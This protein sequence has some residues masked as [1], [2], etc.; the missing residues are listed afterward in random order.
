MFVNIRCQKPISFFFFCKKE[1]VSGGRTYFRFSFRTQKRTR[2]GNHNCYTSTK[3]IDIIECIIWHVGYW[4]MERTT[5][6]VFWC[7]I[8]VVSFRCFD[9]QL[10]F[11]L[12]YFCWQHF[13]PNDD[14]SEHLP[15][16][17][18]MDRSIMN[19]LLLPK[20]DLHRSERDPMIGV[21]KNPIKGD[22]HQ[23][24]VICLWST[25]IIETV[26]CII[27]NY[28]WYICYI[29]GVKNIDEMLFF[30]RYYSSK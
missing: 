20:L 11:V 1:Y 3:N 28:V 30:V 12:Y 10:L 4:I 22:K 21:R 14:I 26:I 27:C 5:Y 25:P 29:V 6:I 15:N 19:G 17:T 7:F 9:L 8:Y 16:T 13:I 23:M 2:N 18:P 24:R